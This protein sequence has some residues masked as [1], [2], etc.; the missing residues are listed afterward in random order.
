MGKLIKQS[1]LPSRE[2]PVFAAMQLCA[3]RLLFVCG[4]RNMHSR[5]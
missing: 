3:D 5:L 1:P 4:Y 2:L